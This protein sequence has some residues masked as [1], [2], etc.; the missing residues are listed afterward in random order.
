MVKKLGGVPQ[1]YRPVPD[2]YQLLKERIAQAVRENDMVIVN[3]GSSA[4]SED[5]TVGI[6]RELGEVLVHGIA[7]KPGKPTILG[8]IQRKPV[9][10]IP[11]YPVSAYFAFE[12]FVSPLIKA[13]QRQT[14]EDRP[15]VEAVVSKRIVS[16]LQHREYI[17]MKLGMVENKLIATP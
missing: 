15:V 4:G 2:D 11:G 5:Y 10:G 17:R 7:A 16:S 1:R 13:F 14:M 12:T 3:A 6:I 8:M 9:F